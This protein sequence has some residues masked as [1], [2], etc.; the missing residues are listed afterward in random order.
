LYLRLRYKRNDEFKRIIKIRAGKNY[1]DS[2]VGRYKD[3]ER[4]GFGTY[5]FANVDKWI[6]NSEDGKMHTATEY[7]RN[8]KVKW[9]VRNGYWSSY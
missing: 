1:G 5:Y 6:G 2:Y 7:D 4:H 3:G 8:G 9:Y